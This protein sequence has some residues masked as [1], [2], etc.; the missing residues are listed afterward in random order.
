MTITK[1][2]LTFDYGINGL[3]ISTV[4]DTRYVHRL[5][6]GYSKK[7]AIRMFLYEV[8]NLKEN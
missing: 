1:N 5:Y 8:N 7:E 2:D 4:T 6:I 3:T